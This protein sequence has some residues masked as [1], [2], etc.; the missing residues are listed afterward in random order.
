MI[1]L[2]GDCVGAASTLT[3]FLRNQHFINH[4]R[5][6]NHRVLAGHGAGIGVWLAGLAAAHDDP[7]LAIATPPV[8]PRGEDLPI[9]RLKKRKLQIFK[10]RT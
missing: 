2:G 5:G 7:N 3:V 10:S 9:R 6:P 4:N 8:T 1:A